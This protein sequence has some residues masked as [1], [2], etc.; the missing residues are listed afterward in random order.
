MKRYPPRRTRG[1]SINVESAGSAVDAMRRTGVQ[2][3]HVSPCAR[4]I[5]INMAPPNGNPGGAKEKITE[6]SIPE[7]GSHVKTG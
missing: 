1:R 3:G 4:Q 5:G 6:D 7:E 2:D